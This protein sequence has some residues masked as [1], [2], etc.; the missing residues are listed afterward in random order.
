M[1]EQVDLF[2]EPVVTGGAVSPDEPPVDA[3]APGELR[4]RGGIEPA[5]SDPIVQVLVE[6]ELPH[7]AR[8]FDYAVPATW[9]DRVVPG[10]RVRVRFAGRLVSGFVLGRSATTEHVGELAP[11]ERVVSD[12]PVLTPALQRLCE[13]VAER[14]AGTVPDVLRLAI[15]PRH[16]KGEKAA[17]SLPEYAPDEDEVF[18]LADHPAGA[19][20]PPAFTDYLHALGQWAAELSPGEM[21][22]VHGPRAA[23]TVLPGDDPGTGWVRLG[24]RAAAEVIAQG[25]TALWLVPDHRELEALRSRL[26]ALTEHA[27]VLTA[28]QDQDVRWT[29]W[30]RVLTGRARLV[31]GTRTAAY[32]PLVDPGIVICTMDQDG[33]YEERRSPYPHAREVLLTRAHLERSA[34]LFLDHGRSVDVQ[35]LVETGWAGEVA[36]ERTF[37]REHTPLVFLPD[38]D[39]PVERRLLSPRAFT[40][41]RE[42]LGRTKRNTAVGPVLV[43]VPRTGFMPVVACARCR[44]VAR[45]PDCENPLTAA[46]AV[47]P[48]SCKRCTYRSGEFRCAEC[49]GNGVRSVVSGLEKIHLELGRAFPG[50]RVLRSGGDHVRRTVDPEP[51]IVVATTGAEPYTEGGYALGLLLDTLWP[52]PHLRATDHAVDRRLRAAS[53]VRSSAHGG[54]VL[55]MDLDPLVQRAVLRFDPVGYAHAQLADRTHLGLPPARRIVELTGEREAVDEVIEALRAVDGPGLGDGAAAGD[56]VAAGNGAGETPGPGASAAGGPD[57]GGG[58][59]REESG[60]LELLVEKED[61]HSVVL[62]FP[63]AGGARYTRRLAEITASRSM[64]QRP[65]VRARLDAP[66]AL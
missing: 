48:F 49:G 33:S 1:S 43:Q 40:M 18:A 11:I 23:L 57:S 55:L 50:V 14:Y 22:G 2:G 26:G 28:D 47:G 35:R 8:P 9:D 34:A 27:A 21:P 12:L 16:A 17:L 51:A 60:S 42:A 15:P 59:V 44:A 24:M 65:Q 62:A 63:V 10:V 29:E 5:E 45:C 25:R 61:P 31:I 52:G 56:G 30:V 7:L 54:R 41:M 39:D 37:R 4:V 38:E 6:T 20:E 58:P 32:A 19:D 64:R 66:E 46:T 3:T 53:L 36:Q 13:A